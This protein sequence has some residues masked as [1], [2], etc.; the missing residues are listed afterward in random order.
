MQQENLQIV[1]R[2]EIIQI[3]P[4]IMLRYNN[5]GSNFLQQKGINMISKDGKK[6]EER[7]AANTG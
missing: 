1:A 4:H 7:Q 6:T 3:K 2:Q 5:T